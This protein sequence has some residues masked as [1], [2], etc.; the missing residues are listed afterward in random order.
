M[1]MKLGKFEGK[2]ALNSLCIFTEFGGFLVSL[3]LRRVRQTW[4]SGYGVG[5]REISLAGDGAVRAPS[6]QMFVLQRQ[7]S[8]LRGKK[9][10]HC[11]V[12]PGLGTTQELG[13]RVF[14]KAYL[15]TISLDSKRSK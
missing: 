7:A 5:G 13:V 8:L 4:N 3:I 11:S 10:C 1:G 14:M 12:D 2:T 6:A 15:R 9:R